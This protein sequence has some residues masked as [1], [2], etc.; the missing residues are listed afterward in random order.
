MIV[1]IRPPRRSPARRYMG[2]PARVAPG[3]LE[4]VLPE[5]VLA[6]NS[7]V[8]GEQAPE[9]LP[10]LCTKAL[11]AGLDS[12][13]L[14]EVAG[15]RPADYQDARER[16]FVAMQELGYERPSPSAARWVL[17]CSW[18]AEMLDGS[19]SPVGG[20]RRIWWDACQ[21]LGSPPELLAFVSLATDWEELEARRPE[22]EAEMISEARNLL[23]HRSMTL[24]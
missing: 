21:E 22:L 15:L 1:R 6:L 8:V 23:V 16:F 3:K 10:E 9:D 11:V 20:C 13:A 5:L 24:G 14:R 19:L 12:P 18:A 2:Q 7:L 17:V 4:L